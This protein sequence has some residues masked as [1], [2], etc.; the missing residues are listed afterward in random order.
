VGVVVQACVHAEA[1]TGLVLG[2]LGEARLTVDDRG[3]LAEAAAC[4]Q[5]A[6]ARIAPHRH[7]EMWSDRDRGGRRGTVFPLRIS[8]TRVGTLL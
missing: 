3:Q 2:R 7:S 4:L 8:R 6:A 1:H 5:R